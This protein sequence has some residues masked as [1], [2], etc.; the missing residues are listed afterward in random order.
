MSEYTIKIKKIL[1]EEKGKI[2]TEIWTD[3]QNKET[4]KTITKRIWWK[5]DQGIY[6]DGTGELPSQF[7]ESVDN[8]W[9]E[10]SR[11]W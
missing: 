10:K 6:R 2:K 9:I 3:I 11:K 1:K 4:G 7:R 5:D 8:I